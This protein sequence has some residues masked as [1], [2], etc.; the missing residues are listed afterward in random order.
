MAAEGGVPEG[1]CGWLAE[2]LELDDQVVIQSSG[3]IRQSHTGTRGFGIWPTV[4]L[5]YIS[6][7]RKQNFIIHARVLS[8]SCP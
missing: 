6:R 5:A 1:I 4:Y 7:L 8:S 2:G 3:I